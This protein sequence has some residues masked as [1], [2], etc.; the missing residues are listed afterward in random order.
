MEIERW[1]ND[2]TG[3]TIEPD[4]KF[5]ELRLGNL[6]NVRCRTCN[7]HSSTQWLKEYPDLQAA[8]PF[9][10]RY[11]TKINTRWTES[12]VF[13]T[14]LLAN[15]ANVEVIY[16]NGGEPTLVEQHWIYLER[17]INHGLNHKI[18]LW[19]SINMTNLPDKLLDLWRQFKEVEV[20]ASI[21]DL[22]NRNSYIR[23]GTSWTDV[24]ANLDKLRNNPWITS[25]VTQT[26]SWMNIYYVPEFRQAMNNL[27][28]SVNTNIVNDPI[29][30]SPHIL[31]IKLKDRLEDKLAHYPEVLLNVSTRVNIDLFNQ[32]IQYNEYLD[33]T[34]LESYNDIFP[35]WA[36]IIKQL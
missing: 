22:D 25:S 12:D 29:F 19:Y 30:Y 7:P 18:K 1:G 20:H 21:D 13:W 26:V 5:I 2:Y 31:P 36:T 33:R 17:L 34:R 27:G 32:G 10:T 23:R 6:C 14:D 3:V 4:L 11:D 15:S 9:V 24:L 35:E 16:I 8:L 28:F